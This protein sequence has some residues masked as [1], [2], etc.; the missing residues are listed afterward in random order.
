MGLMG[1]LGMPWLPY[2]KQQA[3]LDGR[4]W[5]IAVCWAQGLVGDISQDFSGKIPEVRY[6]PLSWGLVHLMVGS[7]FLLLSGETKLLDDKGVEACGGGQ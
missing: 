1:L 6:L 7:L 4:V 5:L 3:E 2:A